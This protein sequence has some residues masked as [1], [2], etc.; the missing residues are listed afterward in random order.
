VVG[1]AGLRG[2]VP[3]G[4]ELEMTTSQKPVHAISA[5]VREDVV[6]IEKRS[7]ERKFV[8]WPEMRTEAT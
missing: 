3:G 6:N 4:F 1:F 2:K 7:G 8:V 5:C